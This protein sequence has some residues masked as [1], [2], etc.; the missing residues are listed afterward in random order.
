MHDPFFACGALLF[1]TAKKVIKKAAA[2]RG[3]KLCSV[4]I[5]G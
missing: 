4:F 2:A 1:S 5:S 3:F